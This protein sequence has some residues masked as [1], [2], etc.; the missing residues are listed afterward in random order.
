M[1]PNIYSIT[2]LYRHQ[3]R[4][5]PQPSPSLRDPR[6]SLPL[7]PDR[8]HPIK[9]IPPAKNKFPIP[10][11]RFSSLSTLEFVHRT[12]RLHF[13]RRPGEQ[14]QSLDEGGGGDGDVALRDRWR[15]RKTEGR[16]DRQ[17]SQRSSLIAPHFNV[18][19]LSSV[20]SIPFSSI[21]LCP[22]QMI[23]DSR[24]LSARWSVTTVRR[25]GLRWRTT[26]TSPPSGAQ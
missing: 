26:R 6:Y 22:S 23:S 20:T 9:F 2:V 12:M 8:A 14:D 13:A 25:S 7:K 11:F 5:F 16:K 19:E 1:Q 18:F 10:V 4:R 21:S 17:D 15:A 24:S 3:T